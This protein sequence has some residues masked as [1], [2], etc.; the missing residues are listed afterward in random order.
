MASLDRAPS[1]LRQNSFNED[2]TRASLLVACTRDWRDEFSEGRCVVL[3]KKQKRGI[4]RNNRGDGTVDVQWIGPLENNIWERRGVHELLPEAKENFT[5]I[6]RR[7]SESDVYSSR[8]GPPKSIL[9]KSA[10]GR[11]R[12]QR[13]SSRLFG[14]AKQRGSGLSKGDASVCDNGRQ[15]SA[16]RSRSVSFNA[17]VERFEHASAIDENLRRMLWYSQEEISG[18]IESM[19]L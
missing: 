1:V 19:S 11:S 9:K 2:R 18:M 17:D 3:V 4:V 7:R 14:A 6:A 13:L 5:T 8:R 12:W 10:I 16:R 15:T